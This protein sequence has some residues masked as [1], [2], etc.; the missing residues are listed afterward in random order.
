MNI[1]ITG[2]TNGIGNSILKIFKSENHSVYG[3]SRNLSNLIDF[4]NQLKVDLSELKSIEIVKDWLAY[5]DVDIFF[6][7]AGSNLITPFKDST[8]E[9]YL[10]SFNLH[11]LSA[12]QISRAILEKKKN[13]SILKIIFF[14]SI[15]SNISAHSRGPY[16]VSK[17]AL[18]SLAKQIAIEHV[19]E[20]VQAISLALGF[21]ETDLTKLTKDDPR[22][23]NAKERYLFP[24]N[25]FPKPDQV[26]KLIS[27]FA[28]QD[29][30]MLNGNTINFDGGITLQ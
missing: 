4:S 24:K 11:F 19:Y 10:K 15:W 16:S 25:Q 7:C 29:L 20:N 18:N 1:L 13:N 30:S 12:S 28:L 27:E 3:I 2:H 8:S 17:G 21:V 5:I 22:I 9:V 23:K 26:A 6:H 14:S